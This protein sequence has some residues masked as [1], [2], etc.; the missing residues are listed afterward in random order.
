M[1]IKLYPSQNNEWIVVGIIRKYL[2]Y[3]TNLRAGSAYKRNLQQNPKK[4]R[5]EAENKNIVQGFVLT[6]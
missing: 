1:C 2:I 3:I 4:K 5:P 6:A